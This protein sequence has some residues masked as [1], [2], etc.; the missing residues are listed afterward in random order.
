MRAPFRPS[1]G[2]ITLSRTGSCATAAPHA[3]SVG[4]TR[5][6]ESYRTAA[7]HRQSAA[8]RE[9]SA[10]CRRPSLA[11]SSGSGS[12]WPL[13][14]GRRGSGCPRASRNACPSPDSMRPW[15]ILEQ[16][17]ERDCPLV[18]VAV[19]QWEFGSN[20]GYVTFTTL[21]T[22][23]RARAGLTYGWSGGATETTHTESS[24]SCVSAY[25]VVDVWQCD[26]HARVR[27]TFQIFDICFSLIIEIF[28]W[29]H[30]AHAHANK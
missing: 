3:D 18:V 24:H 14:T 1:R 5:R 27:N 7:P 26:V 20:S 23:A 25:G 13:C 8:P 28:K 12:R 19:H 16:R 21:A 15:P 4:P 29:Q 30:F 6:T 9:I 11:P 22:H 10:E 2:T 17:K